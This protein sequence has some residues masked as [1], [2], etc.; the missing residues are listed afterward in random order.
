MRS[1]GRAAALCPLSA[2]PLTGDSV[3]YL[4]IDS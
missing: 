1:P 3:K 4:T 2:T